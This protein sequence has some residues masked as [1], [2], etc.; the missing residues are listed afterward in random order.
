M[1]SIGQPDDKY[2][3]GQDCACLRTD[4]NFQWADNECEKAR[5]FICESDLSAPT[6]APAVAPTAAPTLAPTA[7]PTVAPTEAP[8]AAPV[9]PGGAGGSGG[10]GGAGGAGGDEEEGGCI[11]TFNGQCYTYHEVKWSHSCVV[12]CSLDESVLLTD[13]TNLGTTL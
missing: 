12:H 3:T 4:K 11:G 6:T 7:A 2:T 9:A 8:T 1:I 5:T 13:C 10:A